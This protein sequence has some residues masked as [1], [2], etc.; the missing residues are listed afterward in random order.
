MSDRFLAFFSNFDFEDG[1]PPEVAARLRG[2]ITER[3]R[4][5][6]VCSDPA[7]HEKLDRYAC[8]DY[9][10]FKNIGIEFAER[11][12][13]DDRVTP[14]R[15]IQIIRAAS[16]LFLMG[17]DT[18][19]Q[20]QFLREYSLSGAI[21]ESGAPV[22]GLS[23]GAI[24]MGPLSYMATAMLA[25]PASEGLGLA[26][27][28]VAPHYNRRRDTPGIMEEIKAVSRRR[29]VYAMCDGS[30]IFVQGDKIEMLG[31]IYQLDHG[32]IEGVSP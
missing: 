30:A 12:V 11:D 5:V 8:R 1:F 26:D 31:E 25:V 22:L 19:R 7:G 16:C 27:I 3:E 23:A 20:M 6:F 15:A 18:A 32:M 4:L 29:P 21:R 2:S 17:G 9:E 10:W 24:N 13:I 14:A 28:T